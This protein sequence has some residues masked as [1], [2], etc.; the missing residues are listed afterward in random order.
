MLAGLP[1]PA[2]AFALQPFTSSPE[3]RLPW[4]LFYP[5]IFFSGWVGG[6]VSGLTATLLS[7]LLVGWFILPQQATVGHYWLVQMLLV[8]L[9]GSSASL[10]FERYRFTVREL[11]A[12]NRKSVAKSVQ[13]AAIGSE[14]RR[15][16]EAAEQSEQAKSEFL[17]AA[18]HELRTPMASVHG[19]AEL[20]ASRE[21]D[22]ATSRT[23]ARTI[24]R[25][26]SLLVQLVNELL[27]LA[28]IEAGR[29]LDFAMQRQALWPIVC[30]T[31][32]SLIFPDD[33]RR[34]ELRPGA[35]DSARV[36]VD[37]AKLRQAVTNVL[38]NAFKYSAGKGPIRVT[39][40]TRTDHGQ[41]EAGIRVEDEGIGMSPEQLSRVFERF[42]RAEPAGPVP[43][44]GLGLALTKE[45]VEAMRGRV[46]IASEPGRGTQV[47]LWL[48]LA[49]EWPS[50]A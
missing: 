34:V 37:P 15:A 24:H 49:P 46:E 6:F 25:Q 27:D 19:F 26:S 28:R 8:L 21:F 11:R 2:L 33:P 7:M 41:S 22:A 36:V 17:S 39:L 10:I 44:T 48:P 31:A 47:T 38:S 1:L 5:A 50:Q 4:I 23:I 32:D 40:V 14:L 13:L 20:L 42:Y 30:E 9:I 18:A 3:H 29:G 16:K 12:A 45:I 43:G 35:G